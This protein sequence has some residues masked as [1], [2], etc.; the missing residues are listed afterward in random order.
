MILE[1]LAVSLSVAGA[2]L[3]VLQRN[4]VRAIFGLAVA[5][6]GVAIAFLVLD[7]PF[8]AAMEVL[9]YIGGITVAMVFAI[10]LSAEGR[11]A[12]EASALRR[13]VGALLA[14]AFFAGVAYAI[15]ESSF[16]TTSL[17]AE[18]RSELASV[19]AIGRDLLDRFNVVFELLSIVLLVAI[20]GA[21]TIATREG[22]AG[23]EDKKA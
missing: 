15:T 23:T 9:I 16:P 2:M 10:M 5:L 6:L 19:E 12:V 21:V 20:L 18:A 7:A 17:A 3:A 11:L 22:S 14:A 4:M 13:V 1:A 8:V